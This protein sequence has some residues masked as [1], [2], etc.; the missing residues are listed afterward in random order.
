M[1]P[2]RGRIGPTDLTVMGGHTAPPTC[3]SSIDA[4]ATYA[5]EERTSAQQGADTHSL[6]AVTLSR[7]MHGAR[8]IGR[9]RSTSTLKSQVL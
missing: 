8:R 4:K 3:C 7:L 9:P 6:S 1:K 5:N 2:N